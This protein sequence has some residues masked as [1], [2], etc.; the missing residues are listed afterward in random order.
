MSDAQRYPDGGARDQGR[1]KGDADNDKTPRPDAD[2]REFAEEAESLWR[3]TFAPLVWAL[4]FIACYGLVSL[5]C[6]KGLIGYET[7][8]AALLALTAA[9]LAAILWLGWRSL[10]QWGPDNL[11]EAPQEVGVPEP[12]HQFLGHAAFLLSII[13]FIG[14]VFVTLPLLLI[15]G[16][17]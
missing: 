3:I 9:A 1:A 7:S 14:V 10:R 2:R 4:H 8:R 6:I 17:Q 12:R 16:C 15:G 11:A 5:A 13:S